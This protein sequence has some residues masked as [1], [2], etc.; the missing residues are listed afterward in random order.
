MYNLISLLN[1]GSAGMNGSLE[2]NLMYISRYNASLVDKIKNITVYKNHYEINTN[3]SG[4]YNLIIN[5]NPVHSL[6]GAQDEAAALF[7]A[8]PHNSR[9]SV[10]VIFGLGLGYVLDIFSQ[11][12]KGSIILFEPDLE[13]LRLVF[14]AVDL[15]DALSRENVFVV[16]D[17]PEFEKVFESVFRY[18]TRVSFS[19]LDYYLHFS[20]DILECFK[21]ELNRLYSIYSFNF[22]YQAKEMN[23]FFQKTLANLSKKYKGLLLTDNK[24]KFKNIP[25]VIVSAGP[26]LSKNIEILK[27]YKDNAIIFC[28]GTA[29]K[30]LYKNDIIPDF[31]NVIEK[32]NTSFHYDL[33]CTKDM[34]LIAEPYTSSSVF[35]FEFKERFFSVSLEVDSNRWFLEKANKEFIPFETKGTVSY[36]AL[37]SA[38]YLGCSPIILIGQDLAY[39]DGQC[40]AKGSEF[41]GLECI[42]DETTGV[43]KICPR[44]FEQYKAA[45]YKNNFNWSDEEKTAHLIA[46][47]NKLNK[48]LVFVDSQDGSKLPTESG[49]ALFLEY[50]KDFAKKHSGEA[51]LINCSIGG[52]LIHGFETQTLEQTLSKYSTNILD[53][54]QLFDGLKKET[55]F[56][57]EL[58]IKNLKDDILALNEVKTLFEKG[59]N[60]VKSMSCSVKRNCLLGHD[61]LSSVKKAADLYVNITNNFTNKNRLLKMLVL[62]ENYELGYFMKESDGEMSENVMKS[63]YSLFD[64]YYKSG[65]DR[66]MEAESL[67]NKAIS[68][69]KE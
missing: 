33:P 24:N 5:K 39:T 63:F 9:N 1:W 62:K 7:S 19:Y 55:S 52:A 50:I 34:M 68:E 41:D 22:I 32:C 26:S 49:Y 67:I 28:V 3:L 53:K 48:S 2:K 66:I 21:N 20:S 8:L 13:T 59:K 40:Y 38:L 42:K 65:L 11:K 10:H 45:Y 18:K 6:T 51:E 44:N 56:D 61:M 14:E 29:L 30:T 27:K 36:Q 35:D 54:K 15:G 25:A 16:S 17:L 37:S 69:L 23:L 46:R 47:L 4:E 60:I 64:D 12:T 58:I 31:L 57:K 43:Y